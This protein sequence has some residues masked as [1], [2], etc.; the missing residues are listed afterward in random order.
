MSRKRDSLDNTVAESSVAATKREMMFHEDFETR[1]AAHTA[2]AHH[3]EGVYNPCRLA[4]L[5]RDEAPNFGGM[6]LVRYCFWWVV[7]LLAGCV[8]KD[9]ALSTCES[10]F[11][12]HG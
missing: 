3:I 2:I 8:P 7:V 9:I 11:F 10:I 12:R 4:P 1:A 6:A 5:Q